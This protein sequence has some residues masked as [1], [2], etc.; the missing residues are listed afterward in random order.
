MYIASLRPK[1]RSRQSLAKS[2]IE[3]WPFAKTQRQ[4]VHAMGILSEELEQ[5]VLDFRAAR[6]W[7]Q[8]HNSI[9]QVGCIH[10]CQRLELDYVG[11]IIG[12]DLLVRDGKVVT[13]PEGRSR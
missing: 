9:D 10:T 8:F 13:A 7:K 3:G 2:P 6:D 12:P 11:V 5:A 4:Q 1:I